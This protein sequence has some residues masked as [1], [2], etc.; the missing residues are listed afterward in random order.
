MRFNNEEK[1]KWLSE[2][3]LSGKSAWAYAKE[4]G[5]KGQTFAKW[6]KKR[7]PKV[8]NA[9]RKIALNCVKTYV[10]VKTSTSSGG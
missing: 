8:L 7:K 1:S 9:V 6:A 4:K 10:T 3:K 5:F 2:W